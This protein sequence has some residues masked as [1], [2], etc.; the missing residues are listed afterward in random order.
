MTKAVFS[1]IFLLAFI[2]VGVWLL[3]R[4]N[5][6]AGLAD[7]DSTLATPTPTATATPTGSPM[8]QQPSGLQTQELVIG[9]GL[10]AKPGQLVTVH[11]VGT[12]ADGSKFDSSYDRGQPFQ[13]IL[14]GGMVIKG[15]D[16]GVAGMRVGGK[17]KLVIPGDL[18]Y[19]QEGR[20]PVIPSN[21]TLVFEV[22]LLNVQTQGN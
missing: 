17:R 5:E 3:V 9:S 19:G 10:E 15:W 20:P 11:Y 13:F 21:A 1:F 4:K 12:L 22:E 8:I 2:A 6:T 18:A 16:L 14:G 7:L